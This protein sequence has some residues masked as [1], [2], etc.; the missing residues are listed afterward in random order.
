VGDAATLAV[1]FFAAA[2]LY[3]SVG[4]AGA[5]AY[6]AAMAL[7]GVPPAAM[8]PTALA[9]NILVAS[10]VTLRF[11]RAGLVE[12]RALASFAVPSVPLAFVGGAASLP[13]E[14]YKP[15]A[16]V[17]LLLA[18]ARLASTARTAAVPS[19]ATPIP[20]LPAAVVGGGI[21]LLSGLTGTGGGI[22]LTPI[23]LFAG[24]AQPRQAAGI[25]AGFILANSVSGLA[26][27]LASVAALPSALPLWM[28]A[29]VGGAFIGSGLGMRRLGTYGLRLALSAVLLIA[30]L[31]LVFLG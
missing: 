30:G 12:W 24:W 6:L 14:V 8:K 1:L 22:F 9:M 16:G 27:N 7:L 28:A 18:A 19:P 25:S 3:S 26:G 17:V 2:V 11:A 20:A 23:L 4:H 10:L 21:G 13:G 5:S 29:V 15:L 31:K